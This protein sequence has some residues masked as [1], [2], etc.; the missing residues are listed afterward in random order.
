[1]HAKQ[2]V[3]SISY[4]GLASRR[5]EARAKNS[6]QGSRSLS[7]SKTASHHDSNKKH[8][9]LHLSLFYT[10]RRHPTRRKETKKNKGREQKHKHGPET[11]RVFPRHRLA[12]QLLRLLVPDQEQTTPEVPRCRNRV[13]GHQSFFKGRKEEKRKRKTMILVCSTSRLTNQ[14]CSFIPVFLGGINQ[15]S[16]P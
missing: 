8:I 15:N 12:V 2:T 3:P 1:M 13:R 4:L 9:S 6:N 7:A 14:P 16:G 11:H 10:S 5:G